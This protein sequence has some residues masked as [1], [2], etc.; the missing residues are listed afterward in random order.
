MSEK[1]WKPFDNPDNKVKEWKNQSGV[2]NQKIV[3]GPDKGVHRG[4][5]TNTGKTFSTTG[6]ERTKDW[7]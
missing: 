2:I 3:D 5:D 7:E 6:S 4:V 1:D